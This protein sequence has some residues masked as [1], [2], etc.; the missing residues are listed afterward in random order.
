MLTEGVEGDYSEDVLMDISE[1][2]PMEI[3]VNQVESN[4]EKPKPP[5]F[6]KEAVSNDIKKDVMFGDNVEIWLDNEIYEEDMGGFH[7][8]IS[9]SGSES[10]PSGGGSDVPVDPL[11]TI[12]A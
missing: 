10:K 7:P 8:W 4:A 11:S 5:M 6:Y 2:A 9:K 12:F 3:P 1:K